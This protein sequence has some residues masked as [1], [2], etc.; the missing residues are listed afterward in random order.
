MAERDNLRLIHDRRGAHRRQIERF[1]A[2]C[3][4]VKSGCSRAIARTAKSQKEQ[5]ALGIDQLGEEIKG[6]EVAARCQDRRD[7]RWS[8]PNTARSRPDDKRLIE[9]S[10]KYIIDR[11]MA[12]AARRS[13]RGR[14]Q[15]RARQSPHRAKSSLQIIAIDE[16]ARTEAQRELSA[17][18]P[19]LSELRER[20][21]AIEDRLRA[22]RYSRTA[23]AGTVNDSQSTPSAALSPRPRSWSRLSRRCGAEDRS[24]T[25]A[26]RYRPGFRR[27]DR[28]TS[29]FGVQ[30][31][32]YTR[33]RRPGCL[34]LASHKLRRG[35]Q[36]AVLSRRNRCIGR[37]TR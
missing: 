1:P 10:R 36:T 23:I 19:K 13:G 11:D 7:L 22:N 30:P 2:L 14:S 20:R 18:E 9:G 16:T 6:L 4:L 3:S 33:T 25:V 37:R 8:R 24:E 17:I 15:Y 28:Q 34:C 26:D 5:L 12:Q 27:S 35:H 31:A 21:V 32:Y 29:L